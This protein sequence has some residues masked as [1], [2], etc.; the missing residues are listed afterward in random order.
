M[1]ALQN[2]LLFL[3]CAAIPLY[4]LPSGGI[5][6]AHVLF[7]CAAFLALLNHE[8]RFSREAALLLVLAA[9]AFTREAFAVFAGVSPWL[10]IQGA[11][12]LFNMTTFVAIQ[13]LVAQTGSVAPF[14]WG[15][16]A[17][18]AVALAGSSCRSGSSS[19]LAT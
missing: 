12:V 8:V 3:G 18:A 16:V 10:L 4:L 9:V 15:A 14:R 5:Q 19:A 7:A 13:T 6:L 11:F 17:A 1:L 2:G